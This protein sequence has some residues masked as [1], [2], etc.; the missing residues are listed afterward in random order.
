VYVNDR[1]GELYVRT[2]PVTQDKVETLIA[3]V[4]T[5]N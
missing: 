1:K 2:S 3:K 4:Q 5:E